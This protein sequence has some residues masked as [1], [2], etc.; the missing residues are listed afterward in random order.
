[1]YGAADGGRQ[2]WQRRARAS[3][4]LAP[5]TRA[6]ILRHRTERHE[7]AG[8][9]LL[10]SATKAGGDSAASCDAT[11][12]ERGAAAQGVAGGVGAEGGGGGAVEHEAGAD[13]GAVCAGVL[14][15][16]RG[17]DAARVAVDGADVHAAP[18]RADRGDAGGVHGLRVQPAVGVVQDLVLRAA[19]PAAAEQDGGVVRGAVREADAAHDE[20][21]HGGEVGGRGGGR[22]GGHAHGQAGAGAHGARGGPVDAVRAQRRLA[23]ARARARAPPPPLAA[24]TCGARLTAAAALAGGCT[25]ARDARRALR[26][27]RRLYLDAPP[28]YKCV[29]ELPPRRARAARPVRLRA[30]PVMRVCVLLVSAL[31]LAAAAAAEAADGAP[32]PTPFP[33]QLPSQFCTPDDY[34]AVASCICYLR[35]INVAMPFNDSDRRE[36]LC[37]PFGPLALQFKNCRFLQQ[38]NFN[39][40]PTLLWLDSFARYCFGSGILNEL[41]E[42]S[43]YRPFFE[44][45]QR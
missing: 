12:R 11:H 45:A 27:A 24:R 15:R 31:A 37:R 38:S 25:R 36:L 20:P 7:A 3:M 9:H 28:H 13:G 17:S 44:A 21:V 4:P 42:R 22:G 23:G 10:P 6:P 33:A 34:R 8:A 32:Q 2:D 43:K 14:A 16:G 35:F 5:P 41:N 19:E 39:V 29:A 26:C 1:M 18:R 30:R 40:F